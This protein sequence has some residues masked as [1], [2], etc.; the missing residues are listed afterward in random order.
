MQMTPYLFNGS[1]WHG[2]TA[3]RSTGRRRSIQGAFIPRDARSWFN[4][5]SRS[6][7]PETRQRIGDLAKYLLEI[8]PDVV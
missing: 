1:V 6:I 3:N 2:H 8:T 5:A 7:R 4:Q